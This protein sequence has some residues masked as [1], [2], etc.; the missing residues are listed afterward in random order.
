MPISIERQVLIQ[1]WEARVQNKRM[2][3]ASCLRRSNGNI[4][5]TPQ[6][7]CLCYIYCFVHQGY[8]LTLFIHVHDSTTSRSRGCKNNQVLKTPTYQVLKFLSPDS[9]LLL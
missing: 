3:F 9:R 2:R 4:L 5:P 6:S 1:Q 8:H 7:T